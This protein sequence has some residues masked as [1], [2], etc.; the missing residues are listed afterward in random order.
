MRGTILDYS[1]QSGQGIISGDDGNRYTFLGHDWSE[2]HAMPEKGLIVDFS[3]QGF[4]AT[5][6]Y[7]VAIVKSDTQQNIQNKRIIAILFAVFLGWMGMHNFYLGQIGWGIFSLFLLFFA[8]L[9][10]L[11]GLCV[12]S[13]FISAI[14]LACMSDETFYRRFKV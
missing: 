8:S 5:Q 6:V 9:V 7:V 2:Q 4:H 13:G 3:V 1:V 10:G 14:I 11:F 12:I